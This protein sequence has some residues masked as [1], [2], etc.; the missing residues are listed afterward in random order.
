MRVVGVRGVASVRYTLK[1]A[2]EDSFEGVVEMA[3]ALCL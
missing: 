1:V 3:I 2:E